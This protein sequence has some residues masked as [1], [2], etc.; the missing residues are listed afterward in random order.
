ME[1]ETKYP[2]CPVCGKL[3]NQKSEVCQRTTEAG[4]KGEYRR[5]H[6]KCAKVYSKRKIRRRKAEDLRRLEMESDGRLLRAWQEEKATMGLFRGLVADRNETAEE[7]DRVVTDLWMTLC[8]QAI[9]T[10]NVDVS[11]VCAYEDRWFRRLAAQLGSDAMDHI[12][13]RLKW[14]GPRRWRDDPDVRPDPGI[15]D[16]LAG[17]IE[18]PGDCM[19]DVYD[20]DLRDARRVPRRIT[21]E[22]VMARIWREDHVA[23]GE[24]VDDPGP[25]RW[26]WTPTR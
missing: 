24:G 6:R 9:L 15:P 22:D 1:K 3:V 21:A 7:H 25:W 13:G 4:K 10:M 17:V 20:A 11:L 2:R 8:R 16:V 23:G 19:E 26:G 12:A 5:W 14:V 18:V